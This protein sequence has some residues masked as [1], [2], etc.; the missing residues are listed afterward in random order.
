MTLGPSDG[1]AVRDIRNRERW[2]V[3][4]DQQMHFEPHQKAESGTITFYFTN[5]PT[6]YGVK[7]LWD[8]LSKWG[9]V[10]DVYIPRKKN[11]QGKI[12]GFAR[13]KDILYPQELK[14]R[15]DQIWIGTYKLKANCTRFRRESEGQG[16][17]RVG[18]KV[19]PHEPSKYYMHHIRKVA[20]SKSFSDVIQRN[21]GPKQGNENSK[22]GK[23]KKK[24]WRRK[25]YHR[26]RFGED[27]IMMQKRKTRCGSITVSLVMYTVQMQCIFSR[28]D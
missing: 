6:G 12:F 10:V 1:R 20:K 25:R 2:E 4:N 3:Q 22:Q 26:G 23:V 24:V 16:V 9:K 8:V 27:F 18:D 5:F 13:F 17:Q 19:Q 21:E 7:A 14:R 28:I 11:K 15:L